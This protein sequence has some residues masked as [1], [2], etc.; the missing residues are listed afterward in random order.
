M[1]GRDMSDED[2]RA[3]Q[4]GARARRM[5]GERSFRHFM[6]EPDSLR[7]SWR[8][9]WEEEDDILTDRLEDE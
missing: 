8:A 3:Y 4:R 1:M 7:E 6:D 2:V 9:G 5:F